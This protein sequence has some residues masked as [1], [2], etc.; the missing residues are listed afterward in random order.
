M[1]LPVL[2]EEVD[3]V[4]GVSVTHPDSQVEHGLSGFLTNK[5]TDKKT[6]KQTNKLGSSRQKK[7]L[8]ELKTA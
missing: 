5:Q 2:G 1:F 8:Y 6:N 4:Q 3:D 7:T